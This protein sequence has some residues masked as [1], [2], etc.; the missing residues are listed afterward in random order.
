MHV[1]DSSLSRVNEPVEFGDHE[2]VAAPAGDQQRLVELWAAGELAG[3]L[4]DEDL[5]AAGG[6]SLNA[7]PPL[8]NLNATHVESRST[9]RHNP[10]HAKINAYRSSVEEGSRHTNR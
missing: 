3:H 1:N 5:P 7:A 10:R 2:L 8:V 6:R 4:V 9:S